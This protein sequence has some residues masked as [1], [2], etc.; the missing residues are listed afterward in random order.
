MSSILVSL[1]CLDGGL[2]SAA[3]DCGR[4]DSNDALLREDAA[5]DLDA[6]P[7]HRVVVY[8][9]YSDVVKRREAEMQRVVSVRR[10]PFGA[11]SSLS[12][13]FLPLLLLLMVMVVVMVMVLLLLLLMVM[14]MI[15][16]TSRLLVEIV[17]MFLFSDISLPSHDLF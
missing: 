17:S 10:S 16:L 9:E 1:C 7:S 6:A 8:A 12:F 15:V 11:A 2:S 3:L 13:P 14:V 4:Y 5:E